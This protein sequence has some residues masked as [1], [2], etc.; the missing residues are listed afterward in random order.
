MNVMRYRPFYE[1]S[2]T[3]PRAAD[4]RV[5]NRRASIHDR[6]NAKHPAGIGVVPRPYHEL[7]APKYVEA[8]KIRVL[9][10]QERRKLRKNI[11]TSS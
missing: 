4:R 6:Q 1:D 11:V 5:R 9:I 3:E 7:G 8:N 2:P 10:D